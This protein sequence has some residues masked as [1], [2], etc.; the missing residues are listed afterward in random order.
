[1]LICV[2]FFTDGTRAADEFV[3]PYGKRNIQQSEYKVDHFVKTKGRSFKAQRPI[4]IDGQYYYVTTQKG[5][6]DFVIYEF[7]PRIAYGYACIISYIEG[8]PQ[9]HDMECFLRKIPKY[10]GEP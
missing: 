4:Q 5:S 10:N 9:H 3:A 2:I 7:I 1:M 6:V 8:E